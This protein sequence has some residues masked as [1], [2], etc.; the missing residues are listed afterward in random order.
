MCTPSTRFVLLL[1][2]LFGGIVAAQEPWQN[3]FDED[4]ADQLPAGF[5]LAAMRQSHPGRW[6]LHR[7]AADGCLAHQ[8]DAKASGYSLAI[9]DHQAPSD[10]SASVRMQA[11]GGGRSGGLV[12]RYQ[13][14][15][16]FYTLLLDLSR[17]EVAVYRISSGNRVRLDVD[18]G[19]ELDPAAW[20]TLK[21]TH[22]DSS[23]RVMLGG[24]RVFE[25]QDRRYDNRSSPAGRVGLVATGDS[26]VCFDDLSVEARRGRR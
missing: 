4:R 15:Q 16:N 5:T 19:L 13:N 18:D 17:G 3:K 12:W 24:I 26:D 7:P 6:F 23:L 20:H 8:A 25:E 1:S 11:T 10:I 2:C 14:D 22:A 9:A 21:V